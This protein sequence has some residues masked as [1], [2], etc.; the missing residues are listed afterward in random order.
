MRMLKKNLKVIFSIVR[1]PFLTNTFQ[2]ADQ[3]KKTQK[4]KEK[5]DREAQHVLRQYNISDQNAEQRISTVVNQVYWHL[6]KSSNE[7][8][9]RNKSGSPLGG[10]LPTRGQ[11]LAATA[12]SSK[13]NSNTRVCD[14]F[15]TQPKAVRQ[16]RCQSQLSKHQTNKSQGSLVSSEDQFRSKIIVRSKQVQPNSK[17][18]R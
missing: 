4:Q 2:K 8:P 11:S 13:F 15:T 17:V 12:C 3:K 9:I 1:S 7:D 14:T 6:R 5:A 16:Q 10:K 18:S